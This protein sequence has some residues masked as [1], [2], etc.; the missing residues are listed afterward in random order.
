MPHVPLRIGIVGAGGIVRSNHIPGFR[1]LE[2]CEIVAVCNRSQE[3]GARVAQEFGIPDVETDWKKLVARKD[4]NTIVVGTWPYL[5][6]DV[7]VA[8][9]KAGKHVLCES[10]MALNA[11]HAHAM[12]KAS[13]DAKKKH[14]LVTMLCPPPTGFRGDYVMKELIASGHLGAPRQ[15][16]VRHMSPGLLDASKPIYWRQQLKYQGLNALTLGMLNEPIER[17]F[18]ATKKVIAAT[19]IFTNKRPEKQGSAK[20]VKVERPDTIS[21]LAEMKNGM[22]A[23]YMFSGVTLLPGPNVI[24][25][26]GSEGMIRYELD[27]DRIFAAR[28]GDQAPKEVP[29][30][31]EKARTWK[32]EAEFVAAIR[33]GAAVTPSFEEGAAYMEFTEAVERSAKTGRAV[34]LPL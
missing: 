17:W 6:K 8:A 2:D 1:A 21:V 33:E 30:P 29:V 15:L 31:A 23:A 12:L 4:L 14:G 13:K 7:S 26:W 16:Y 11:S 20:M 25:A 10:R 3:S 18:G 27:G 19:K 5:H 9:L 22:Q 24:E 32:V 28:K 34:S